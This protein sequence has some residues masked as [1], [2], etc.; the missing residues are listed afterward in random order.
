VSDLDE[1]V[2]DLM[3]DPLFSAEYEKL[4][5][6]LELTKSLVSARRKAGLTA[7]EPARKAG[8]SRHRLSLL[9]SGSGTP[10]IRDLR[11]AAKALGLALRI[12]LIPGKAA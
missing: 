3:Q 6:R 4:R 7:E 1:L 5:W 9:E 10:D 2:S 8:I 12:E 11:R